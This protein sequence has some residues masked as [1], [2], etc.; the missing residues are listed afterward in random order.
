MKLIVLMIFFSFSVVYAEPENN[1]DNSPKLC[2]ETI[3]KK[4][5][6]SAPEG[7]SKKLNHLLSKCIAET[8]IKD[9]TLVNCSCSHPKDIDPCIDKFISSHNFTRVGYYHSVAYHCERMVWS[10]FVSEK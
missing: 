3:Y 8:K 7:V 10:G 1:V 2:L 5:F 6:E 4:N 9:F